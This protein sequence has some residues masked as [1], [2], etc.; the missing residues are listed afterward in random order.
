MTPTLAVKSGIPGEMRGQGGFMRY[1][2][3]LL[4]VGLALSALGG[5]Q[6]Q[7]GSGKASA[8]L[9]ALDYAEIQSLYGRYAHY[10]DTCADNGLAFARL[11]TRDGQF[12]QPDGR[13]LEGREKFAELARCPAGVTRRPTQ[14]WI[15]SIA[16]VPAAEGAAGSAYVMQVNPAEP[17]LLTSGN[18]YEDIFAKGPDGWG[19]KRHTVV[20][21]LRKQP[22]PAAPQ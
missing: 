2:S 4:A 18:G 17:K 12:I 15:G 3:T 8:T 16:I 19:F 20:P 13:V 14:H 11:F 22:A 10:F 5:A 9:T 1:R 21:T 7:Q 6:A